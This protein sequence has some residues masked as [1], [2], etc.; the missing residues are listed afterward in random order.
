VSGRADTLFSRATALQERIEELDQS[1]LGKDRLADLQERQRRLAEVLPRAQ[2]ARDCLARLARRGLHPSALPG[3]DDIARAR[4]ALLRLKGEFE[5][6][7]S[8]VLRQDFREVLQLAQAAAERLEERARIVWSELHRQQTAAWSPEFLNALDRL[9]PFRPAVKVIRESQATLKQLELRFP[10]TDLDLDR[11]AAATEARK[12]A[13]GQ[14][15]GQRGIPQ[16]V[17]TF[18]TQ[19][20]SSTGFPLELVTSEIREWLQAEGILASFRV[21]L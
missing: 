18:L 2:E 11:F 14:L 9:E 12:R 4:E 3:V 16:P 21:R 6:D 19:C 1:L 20:A 17:V 8:A 13:L 10:P 15:E 5:R 7:R